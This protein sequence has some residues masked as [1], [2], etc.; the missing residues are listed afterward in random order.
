MT[1][2]SFNHK[3]TEQAWNNIYSRLEEEGLLAPNSPTRP[4]YAI[5]PNGVRWIAAITLFCILAAST[6][7]LIPGTRLSSPLLALHNQEAK[8]TLIASL[9]DGSMIYLDNNALLTYPE[10]FSTDKREVSLHGNALFEVNGNPEH[11]FVIE[12]GETQI[13]VTGTS[14]YIKNTEKEPFELSVRQGNVKVTW[15]KNGETV[16]VTAGKTVQLTTTGLTVNTSKNPDFHTYYNNR[17]QFRDIPL[18][19]ILRIINEKN[20]GYEI[21]ASPSLATRRLTVTFDKESP[22]EITEIICTGLNVM[23]TREENTFLISTF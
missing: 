10:H 5:R 23:Y 19:E 20:P 15:K 1:Q 8:T 18:E 11:P 13:E 7:F 12:A 14:F 17:I 4:L 16:H 22:E 2:H 3:K 9:E 6:Y 21:T